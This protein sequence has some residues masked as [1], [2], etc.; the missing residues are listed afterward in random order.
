[1]QLKIYLVSLT[2]LSPFLQG[3]GGIFPPPS[4]IVIIQK[5]PVC[6]GLNELIMNKIFTKSEQKSEQTLKQIR[7]QIAQKKIPDDDGGF[8]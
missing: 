7:K 4:V 1:M 6:I 8:H 5:G 3:G 2:C